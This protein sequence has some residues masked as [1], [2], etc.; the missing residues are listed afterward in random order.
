MTTGQQ[1]IALWR[2]SPELDAWAT[3][4]SWHVELE[5]ETEFIEIPGDHA[6]R[7]T[8]LALTRRTP[9]R[10]AALQ[11]IAFLKSPAARRIWSSTG[12]D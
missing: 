12:W 9:H 5:S 4:K 3:Y 8:P 10:E 1:G 6:A 7:S 2:S 11:F